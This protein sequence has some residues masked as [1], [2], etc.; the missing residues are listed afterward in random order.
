MYYHLKCTEYGIV[1]ALDTDFKLRFK[2]VAFLLFIGSCSTI[3][4]SVRD[5]IVFFSRSIQCVVIVSLFVVVT[6][7]FAMIVTLSEYVTVSVIAI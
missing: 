7:V 3:S 1:G 2:S 4:N 5:E 6:V